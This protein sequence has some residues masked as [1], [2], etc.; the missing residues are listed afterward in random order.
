ML[1][2]YD[3]KK[4]TP[5]QVTKNKN[6]S[7]QEKEKHNNERNQTKDKKLAVKCGEALCGA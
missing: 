7:E 6:P 2:I 3:N 5:L 1:E 4:F